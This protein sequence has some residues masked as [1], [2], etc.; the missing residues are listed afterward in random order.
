M[1]LMPQIYARGTVRASERGCLM[2]LLCMFLKNIF[3]R[4]LGSKPL[5]LVSAVIDTS[6]NTLLAIGSYIPALFFLNEAMLDTEYVPGIVLTNDVHLIIKSGPR[7]CPEWSWD[8][9]RWTFKKTNPCIIEEWMRERAVLAAKKVETISRA[10]YR[11]NNLR[12]KVGTGLL[13]QEMIYAEKEKQ[14]QSLKDA[15]FD[16]QFKTAA[17][18]VVQYADYSGVPLRQAAEEILLQARLDHELLAKTEKVRLE[19]F[20]KIR[21]ANTAEE[22]EQIIKTFRN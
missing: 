6:N 7:S 18:Y 14:A 16:E 9:S 13:F 11:I 21:L 8:R 4:T 3:N 2:C 12:R 1:N 19:I 20:K 15:N 5:A 17:P 10:I 22:L